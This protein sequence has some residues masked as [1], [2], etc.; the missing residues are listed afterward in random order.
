MDTT[1]FDA[2]ARHLAEPTARRAALKTLAATGLAVG[3]T[4]VGLR[5]VPTDAKKGKKKKKGPKKP[6]G[7]QCNKSKTCANG[8]FCQIAND[9]QT[10]SGLSEK[11][12]CKPIGA[13]CDDGCDCCGT[14]VICNGG[15]CQQS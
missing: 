3:L 13:D 2:I 6:L 14:N 10:C 15:Y 7:E 9:S 11:R 12:C 8:L 1:R 5:P 4:R